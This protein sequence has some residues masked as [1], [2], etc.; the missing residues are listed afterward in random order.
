MVHALLRAAVRSTP[1]NSLSRLRPQSSFQ[2]CP[3]ETLLS[4]LSSKDS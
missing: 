2:D 3:W 1:E 4:G